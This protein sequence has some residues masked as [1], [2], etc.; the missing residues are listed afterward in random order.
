MAPFKKQSGKTKV[1]L[2]RFARP[3]FL[4]QT[5]VEYAR[6]S[7]Q[8]CAWA[9]VLA[10]HLRQ[11]GWTAFRIYRVIAFKWIRIMWRCWKDG[12]EYNEANYVAGL[13]RAGVKLYESLYTASVE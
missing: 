8:Y 3:K 5:F 4:H 13:Q 6:V 11:K 9:R 1:V 2:F 7:I 12:I 10:T